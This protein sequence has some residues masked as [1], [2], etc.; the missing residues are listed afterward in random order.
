MWDPEKD[1]G[2]EEAVTQANNLNEL[3]DLMHLCFRKMN[4]CQ[5]EALIGLAL[6]MSSDIFT[7]ISEEEKRR[8]NKSD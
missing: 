4:S 2:I 6:N 3:L 1:T 7:W 8:E 5:T